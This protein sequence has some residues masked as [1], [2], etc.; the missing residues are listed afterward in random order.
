VSSAP[1]T[2]AETATLAA[3]ELDAAAHRS[4]LR[5]LVAGASGTVV[6]QGFS[7]LLGF[8]TTLLL[9][10]LLGSEGYGRYAYAIAWAGLLTTPAILGLDRFLVRGMAVYE[11]KESWAHMKG[12]LRRTNEL[13][14]AS[15]T[16]I[17]AIGC[18]VGLLTLAGELRFTFCVAMALVPLTALTLLRQGAMQAIGRVVSGQLPEF[19]IRPVL[20]LAGVGALAL[21]GH[22]VLTSTTALAAT[23]TGMACAFVAGALILRRALPPAVRSV[24]ARYDT[25]AWLRASLPMMWFAAVWFGN[26]YLAT[27][28]VGTFD[29]PR[30]AGVYSV[31]EKG[32][33]LIVLVLIAM[34]MPLAPVIARMHA[35]GDRPGLQH[36]TERVAQLTLLVSAPLAV[37]LV[38]LRDVYLGFF[39][40]GFHAGAGALTV[41]ALAQLVNAAAGPAG[42]VLIM[43]GHERAAAGGVAVGLL[44]NVALG[45]LLVPPLGVTGGAIAS[46]SSL[47]LWN[48]LLVVRARAGLRVNVTALRWLSLRG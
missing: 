25:R 32:A 15:S 35:R 43:T 39:G 5:A 23:V 17:A 4:V 8:A 13:V 48:A 30:A 41:L 29:G 38:L 22:G 19:A 31:S 3:P 20:V 44:A 26:K 21:A 45:A 11:V 27:L 12:L 7:L 47:V 2:F 40:A 14:L 18:V 6:L 34:N 9:A 37:G 42:N 1:G 28:V 16:A 46:G 36:A 10:H 24:G 33:E